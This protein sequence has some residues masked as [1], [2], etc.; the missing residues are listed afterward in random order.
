MR[1]STTM[2]LR[3]VLA[4]LVAT[5]TP[6]CRRDPA[7]TRFAPSRI[8]PTVATHLGDAT[9]FLW[10]GPGAV[11]TG[12]APGA[13]RRE[14]TSVLRGV[15]RGADGAGLPEVKVTLLGGAGQSLAIS[16]DG[17]T[18]LGTEW[19]GVIAGS[20][21][22]TLSDDFRIGEE[23][24]NGATPIGFGYD[25][26][27]LLTSIG[28]LTI[29]RDPQN[30][31]I[32]GTTLDG[33]TDV[34]TYDGFGAP[35]TS[36]AKHLATTQ[37]A[38]A[39]TYDDLGRVKTQTE[40]ILGEAHADEYDYDARGQLKTWKRDGVV[41]GSYTYDDN[42][43]RTGDG[44]SY[45]AQDRLLA[46]SS[47]SYGRDALGRRTHRVAG[48]ATTTYRWDLYSRLVGVDLA[49]G[50]KVANVYDPLGRIVARR[51]DGAVAEGFLY[52]DMLGPIAQLD[53]SGAVQI[54]F[55]Y[56]TRSECPEY[57]ERDG[58]RY[59]VW[60]DLRGSPRLVVDAATGAVAQRLDYD[61][62]GRVT[63]DTNPGFQPFGFAG[64]LYDPRTQLI[65]FGVRDYDAATA[66]WLSKDPV[67]RIAEPNAYR[68]VG[69]DP[70]NFIDPT[71]L[72]ARTFLSNFIDGHA[73]AR[74]GGGL[75][76]LD[77]QVVA[78]G[79]VEP[80]MDPSSARDPDPRDPDRR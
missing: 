80:C 43:N 25:D 69:N 20:V 18:A 33:T 45:D 61:A 7:T 75:L 29:A 11:Q 79:A 16:Y 64:G 53:A 22:Y 31:A 54:R 9:R 67:G 37:L 24:V 30:G 4:V 27:G 28:S 10:D 51:V 38:Y 76:L 36:T 3:I 65:H 39:W 6:G 14:L 41:V 72:T 21:A 62:W 47:A 57:L 78:A 5:A 42:G 77:Q 48:G 2:D 17:P 71:G 73:N 70:I 23:R 50:Q 46:D 68:Y 60:C 8:D 1:S 56:S 35:A 55:V 12:V 34:V 49:S 52:G 40:E 32:T 15:V 19:S 63:N 26:D 59:R 66:R 58:K 44:A 74:T 13:I